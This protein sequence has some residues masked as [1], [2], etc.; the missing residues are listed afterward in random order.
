[1]L[2]LGRKK[3]TAKKLKKLPTHEFQKAMEEILTGQAIYE[4][5]KKRILDLL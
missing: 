4:T 2:R 5:M 3:Y 1:M